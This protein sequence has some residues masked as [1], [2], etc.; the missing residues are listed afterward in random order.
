MEL[1]NRLVKRSST[2]KLSAPMV[3]PGSETCKQ[4]YTHEKG[5]KKHKISTRKLGINLTQES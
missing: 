2:N 4:I 5:H 3:D 1:K